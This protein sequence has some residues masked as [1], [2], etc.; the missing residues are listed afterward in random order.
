MRNL[1][2]IFLL[3]SL[4]LAVFPVATASAGTSDIVDSERNGLLVQAH[5]ADALAAA[6]R[7][8]LENAPLREA[9]SRAALQSADRFAT[10]RIVGE[11]DM[12]L[13]EVAA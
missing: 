5:V 8:V 4:S 12:L 2:R 3:A 1:A 9:M 13:H 11:Y 10:P 6:L 7:R